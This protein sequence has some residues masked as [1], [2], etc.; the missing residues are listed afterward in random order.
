[1]NARI[2][3][4]AVDAKVLRPLRQNYITSI[5]EL[6]TTIKPSDR[7]AHR[8]DPARHSPKPGPNT[9]FACQRK[10]DTFAELNKALRATDLNSRQRTLGRS[11]NIYAKSMRKAIETVFFDVLKAKGTMICR[12][13]PS[14]IN[15]EVPHRLSPHQSPTT[16]KHGGTSRSV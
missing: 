10:Y 7:Q 8:Q 14:G 15:M 9:R 11:S 12:M 2:G 13:W 16:G 4:D 3:N 6:E 1:M 5:V